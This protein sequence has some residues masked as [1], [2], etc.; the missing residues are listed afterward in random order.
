MSRYLSRFGRGLRFAVLGAGNGGQALA[1]YLAWRG[2]PVRLYNRSAARLEAIRER[3]GVKL[4]GR[5]E[6]FGR[7]EAVTSD[8]GEALR[9]ARV[10]LVVIPASGH[11]ALARAMAPHLAPGQVVVLNPGRTGGA[12]EFYQVFREQEV[13]P[14]VTVAEAQTFIFASRVVGPGRVRVFEIKHRVPVAAIPAGRTR[15]VVRLMRRGL[16]EFVPAAHVLETSLANIGAIFHPAPTLMN[17]ARIETG[18]G[19]DHY[20]EGISPAVARVLEA[21][22]AERL[23]VARALG[24]RVVSAREWLQAAYGVVGSDLYTAIASCSAY[25]GISAP[26]E[27]NNR[28]LSEDVPASLVPIAALGQLVGVATPAINAIVELASLATGVDF[29]AAGRTLERMG[30]AGMTVDGL[31]QYVLR[32]EKIFAASGKEAYSGSG[33]W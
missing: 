25:S 5:F 12:L 13:H 19:F 21:M 18:A 11:R 22:D 20:H 8:L 3:G 29:F 33:A 14:G 32:G 27:V 23:A 9:G 4:E 31:W 1:G 2:F 28:Y 26:D 24:T 6:G 15:T 16:S 7:F 17:A 10:A 30:V